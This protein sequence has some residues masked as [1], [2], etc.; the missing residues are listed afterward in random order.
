MTLLVIDIQRVPAVAIQVD[1][2]PGFSNALLNSAGSQRVSVG[3]F[4]GPEGTC[5]G[6]SSPEPPRHLSNIGYIHVPL[7]GFIYGF[8]TPRRIVSCAGVSIGIQ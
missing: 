7:L 6:R 3:V 1:F 4:Y 2:R 8:V 5:I